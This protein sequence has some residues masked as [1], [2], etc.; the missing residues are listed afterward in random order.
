VTAER[1]DA[2]VAGVGTMGAAALYHLAR[3]GRRV[4]GLEQFGLVHTRGS[5]HG[6]T[7]IIRQA[8][9]EHP[10]YVPLVRRAYELWRTLEQEAG[11]QLLWVVGSLELGPPDGY[12]VPGALHAC[13][14]H[15]LQH[16]LLQPDEVVARFPQFRP[17][18]GTV[19]VYQPDGGFV[20]AEEAVRAHGE[21]A[22]ALGADLHLGERVVDWRADRD[23]VTVRTDARTYV[24]DRLVLTPGAWAADLLR[25][26]PELFK[27]E[28]QVLGWFEPVRGDELS[29]GR[30][31]IFI[32]EETGGGDVVHHYGFPVLDE[33]GLKLGRMHHPGE[34]VDPADVAAATPAEAAVL[35]EFL[36]RVVPEAAGRLLDQTACLF[37]VTPDKA[38]VIDMHPESTAVVFASA[39]SGHGFKFAPVVGEV[40]ADLADEGSTPHAIDFLRL[41]RL[42][43]V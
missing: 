12:L 23:G 2:I 41:G 37:T 9:H 5:M 20:R 4:L 40:L 7:R 43:A 28:R 36:A 16:D 14:V 22:L 24:A 19:G 17:P 35:G 30:M 27:V 10:D 15:G 25:L 8:Y 3:R 13:Q 21:R 33:H 39:C 42:S 34:R 1:Y 18:D 26:P 6:Q 11:E 29:P 32:V 38:F 31:P